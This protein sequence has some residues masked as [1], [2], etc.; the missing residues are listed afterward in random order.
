M[1]GLRTVEGALEGGDIPNW[2]RVFLM[3]TKAHTQA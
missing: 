1:D 3:E 2:H